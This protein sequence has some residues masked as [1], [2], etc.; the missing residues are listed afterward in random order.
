[1]TTYTVTLDSGSR[2]D[3]RA[4]SAADAMQ[5]V[6]EANIGRKVVSCESGI[7]SG[8]RYSG[9]IQYDIPKHEAL[10][11]PPPPVSRRTTTARLPEDHHRPSPGGPPGKASHA[12]NGGMACAYEGQGRSRSHRLNLP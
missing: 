1:M 11:Q 5:R 9:R 7:N 8:G 4:E 12:R 3:I 6:L 10:T 2:R